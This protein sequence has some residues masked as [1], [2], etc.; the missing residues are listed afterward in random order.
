MDGRF[1]NLSAAKVKV[2]VS[3]LFAGACASLGGGGAFGVGMTMV[4]SGQSSHKRPTHGPW[5]ISDQLALGKHAGSM[6]AGQFPGKEAKRHHSRG[7]QCNADSGN[8]SL[9]FC[10]PPKVVRSAYGSRINVR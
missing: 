7:A 10:L 2:L 6:L 4:L 3:D 1:P 5:P 8:G 9:C